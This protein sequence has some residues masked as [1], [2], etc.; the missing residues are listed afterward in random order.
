MKRKGDGWLPDWFKRYKC[1]FCGKKGYYKNF[2]DISLPEYRCMYC[3][4]TGNH[5]KDYK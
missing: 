3:K 2:I 4:K 1:P 5:P